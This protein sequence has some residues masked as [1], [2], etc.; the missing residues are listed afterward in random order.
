MTCWH[1]QQTAQL[2]S[3]VLTAT[4]MEVWLPERIFLPFLE[5]SRAE[6]GID[7]IRIISASRNLVNVARS[8]IQLG[9]LAER[10]DNNPL[11]QTLP[12]AYGNCTRGR[13]AEQSSCKNYSRIIVT[14][15][16]Q[17][18]IPPMIVSTFALILKSANRTDS[19]EK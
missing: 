1:Y 8:R 4:L 16:G 6:I 19:N 18:K 10:S 14:S 11:Q 13:Q 7:R 9:R 2:P 3:L 12:Y 5:T 17:S 15:D